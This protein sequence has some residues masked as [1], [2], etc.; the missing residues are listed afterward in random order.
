MI[1]IPGTPE[2]LPAIRQA[3]EDG[4]NINITLL[5]A[6]S[7]YQQVAEAFVSAMEARAAKGQDVRHI[8]RLASF[9]VS[10]IDTLVDS[11]LDEKLKTATDQAQRSLFESLGG[12]VAIADARLAYKKYQELF[13]GPRW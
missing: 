3:L 9:F 11:R 4:I 13:G 8:A 12:K 7:A 1:K 2:G 10:R 5:F 6:Q